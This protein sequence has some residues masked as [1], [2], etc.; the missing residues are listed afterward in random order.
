M[1]GWEAI[2]GEKSGKIGKN[3]ETWGKKRI[4]NARKG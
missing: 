3:G 2:N 4:K 1:V